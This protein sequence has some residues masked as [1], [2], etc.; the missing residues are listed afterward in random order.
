MQEVKQL[1]TE[2]EG[3][4]RGLK[5]KLATTQLENNSLQE[6]VKRMVDKLQQRETELKDFE[7]QLIKL[8]QQSIQKDSGNQNEKIDALVREIDDC[9]KRLK[10]G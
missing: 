3:K 1:I 2:I 6:E 9:I 10:Q 5:E 8:E 4:V 7:Q